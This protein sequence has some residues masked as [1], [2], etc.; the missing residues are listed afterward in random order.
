MLEIQ[1]G[2]H[3]FQLLGDKGLHWLQ[4]RALFVADTHFGKEATFRH[5]GIPVPIGS[6]QGT[7]IAITK[8]LAHTQATRL[9][10]LGDMFHA[11]SSLSEDV[12]RDLTSFF[13][14]HREVTFT[15]IRGNHDARLGQ[16][17][18]AWPLELSNPVAWMD[19]IALG[20]HPLALP[21][22]ADVYLCGHLHPAI[23]VGSRRDRLGKLPCFWLHD[24]CLVLPA[25]GM[26]TGT[27]SISPATGDRVWTIADGVVQCWQ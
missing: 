12:V 23:E 11:K 26:F 1:I 3:A 6:T 5:H 15:L 27:A 16:L 22:N 8:M 19:R 24:G 4:E 7:L 9:L 18:S 2:P 17:P 14:R 10:I 13:T 21:L 20:H 25:L